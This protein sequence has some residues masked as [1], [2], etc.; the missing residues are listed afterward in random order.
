MQAKWKGLGLMVVFGIALL[1]P[2]S[3]FASAAGSGYNQNFTQSAGHSTNSAVDLTSV[4]SSYSSGSNI[5]VTFSVSGSINFADSNYGYLVWFGGHTASTASAF[6]SFSNGTGGYIASGGSGFGVIVPM[7]SGGTLS[8]SIATAVVGPESTYS[9]DAFAFFGVAATTGTY[10]WLGTDYNGG[11][12]CTS[13]TSCT[14]TSGSSAPFNYWIIVIPV[15]VVVLIVVVLVVLMMRK[16]PAQPGM[17]GQPGQPPM[18]PV[19]PGWGSAPPPSSDPAP[20][21]P[22]PGSM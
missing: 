8:F 15:I 11:G 22:P 21:P 16:K 4:S 9:I 18:Q 10:T 20:P 12:T 7:I 17:M 2:L 13:A 19:Q 5:S 1:L 14:S 3:G 6:A